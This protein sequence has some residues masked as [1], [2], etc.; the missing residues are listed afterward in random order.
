MPTQLPKTFSLNHAA[1]K[2]IRL[3]LNQASAITILEM[4][5]KL[6]MLDK[7]LEQWQGEVLYRE[8]VFFKMRKG[9]QENLRESILIKYETTKSISLLKEKQVLPLYISTS[10][11]STYS[12]PASV[13]D[14]KA[15]HNFYYLA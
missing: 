7:E 1:T 14:K 10:N 2:S 11:F 3:H 5:D 13:K 9:N 6:K 8:K 4:K 15:S 12:R